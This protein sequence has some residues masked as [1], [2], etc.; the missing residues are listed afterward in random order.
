MFVGWPF[1]FGMLL[2]SFIFSYYNFLLI[3]ATQLLNCDWSHVEMFL[4]YECEVDFCDFL[5]YLCIFLSPSLW[6]CM[7]SRDTGCYDTIAFQKKMIFFTLIYVKG[8]Q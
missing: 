7:C 6:L 1:Y 2:L 8:R 5:F 4:F 3:F